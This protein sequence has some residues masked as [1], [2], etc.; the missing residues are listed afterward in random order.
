MEGEQGSDGRR[1]DVAGL[2]CYSGKRPAAVSKL[3]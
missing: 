2:R 1:R 3:S